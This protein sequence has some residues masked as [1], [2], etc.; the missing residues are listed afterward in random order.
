MGKRRTFNL[1]NDMITRCNG[2]PLALNDTLSK[3]ELDELGYLLLMTKLN[4]EYGILKEITDN[5]KFLKVL[6]E[7]TMKQLINSCVISACQK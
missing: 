1:C 7:V 5:Y 3:A 4:E 2:R 6:P